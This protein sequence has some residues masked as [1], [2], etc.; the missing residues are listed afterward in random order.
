M[1]QFLV[2]LVRV[3]KSRELGTE[4]PGSKVEE[5]RLVTKRGITNKVILKFS[6]LSCKL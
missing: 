5:L 2:P 3:L 4:H 6:S 1:E